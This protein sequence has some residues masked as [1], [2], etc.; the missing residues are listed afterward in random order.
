MSLPQYRWKRRIVQFATLLL[1]ALIPALGLLR[2]DLTHASFSILDSQIQWWNFSF[3]LGLALVLATVP[4]I[5]YMTLG[6]VWCGWVCP[7]NLLSEWANNLT[8]KLLG[9]RANVDVDSEGLKVAAAKNK[10]GNWILLAATFLAAAFILA[11]IPFLFFFSLADVWSFFTTGSSAKLSTFM[12]RLYLFVVF[13]VFI[14]IAVV[15]YFLCDYGCLYRIGQK[16]FKNKGALQVVYDESRSGDCARCNYCATSCI[17]GIQ[18]TRISLYDSCIDCGECIDACNRLH[19]KSGTHGLLSFD[20]GVKGSTA[21]WREKLGAVLSRFNWLV[22]GFFLIGVA[23]VVWGIHTQ[24]QLPPEVPLA[25]QQKALHT[26]KICNSQCAG[27]QALCKSG[28][29]EGCLQASYCKCECYLQ[30]DPTNPSSAEWQQCVKVSKA[31]AEALDSR[32]RKPGS[33]MSPRVTDGQ[34]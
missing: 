20:F 32:N 14:D 22:G 27:Q 3:M 8:H 1:I 11:L 25:V 15:R 19:A 18:P 2:I 13:L 17:T 10:V 26:A 31:H 30:Q 7:Q 12:Q 33:G 16:I 23:M 9:K 6:T 5:I 29:V 34:K 21:T 24:P 28:S 4:I